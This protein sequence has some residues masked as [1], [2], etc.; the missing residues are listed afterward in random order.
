MNRG[1]GWVWLVVIAAGV[2]AVIIYS[3]ATG[4]PVLP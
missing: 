1:A 2:I 4:Q 3:L